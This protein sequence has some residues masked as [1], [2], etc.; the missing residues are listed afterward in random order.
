MTIC[1]MMDGFGIYG[2]FFHYAIV[3]ALVGSAFFIFLYLW[4]KNRLDMDE[5]PK[6]QMMHEEEAKQGEQVCRTK[7][8]T[9]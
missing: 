1:A 9:K 5:E 7:E 6:F 3:I 4:K 2:H 8:K